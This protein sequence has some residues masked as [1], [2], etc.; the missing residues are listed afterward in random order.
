L[1]TGIADSGGV[2]AWNLGHNDFA[3]D[4]NASHYMGVHVTLTG[5][6]GLIAPFLG[7]GI[8][9]LLE[10]WRPGSGVWT[11]LPCLILNS[12]GAMGFVMMARS[13]NSRS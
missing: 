11:F 2:L 13:M 12:T 7:V 9:Q 4:H 5:I 8:Y 3:K 1:L 10:S 6:R